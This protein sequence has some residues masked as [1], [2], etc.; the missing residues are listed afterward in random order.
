MQGPGSDDVTLP[1][2]YFKLIKTLLSRLNEAVVSF[3]SGETQEGLTLIPVPQGAQGGAPISPTTSTNSTGDVPFNSRSSSQLYGTLHLLLCLL[4]SKKVKTEID[5]YFTRAFSETV[6]NTLLNLIKSYEECSSKE[7]ESSSGNDNGNGKIPFWPLWLSPLCV[8]LFELATASVSVTETVFDAAQMVGE[9]VNLSGRK[10]DESEEKTDIC[11]EKESDVTESVAEVITT[12]YNQINTD[13]T[14]IE[15]SQKPLQI[16]VVR[17]VEVDGKCSEEN[18][19]KGENEEEKLCAAETQL[20]VELG[21]MLR[22]EV[23]RSSLLSEGSWIAIYDT[24]STILRGASTYT[25]LS[26]SSSPP[27]IPLQ[28]FSPTTQQS[29]SS[30][31]SSSSSASS[32][33]SSASSSIIHIKEAGRSSDMIKDVKSSPTPNTSVKRAGGVGSGGG[34]G[35]NTGVERKGGEDV[36]SVQRRYLDPSS[37]QGVLLLLHALVL[38]Q[39]LSHRFVMTGGMHC[40]ITLSQFVS[41]FIFCCHFV[42]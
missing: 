3:S 28:P 14:G 41:S 38:K 9:S 21:G 18:E 19:N 8:L 7:K 25:S 39:D 27:S 11:E 1:E 33:T 17:H 12:N 5:P 23:D 4:R 13:I 24:I 15:N 35:K 31:S 37:G 16:D 2:T 32:S 30:S 20:I 22:A 36:H 34:S 29:S 26:P 6:V 10:I 40:L 42:F